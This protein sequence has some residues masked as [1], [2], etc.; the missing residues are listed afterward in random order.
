MNGMLCSTQKAH[1]KYSSA[2]RKLCS[3]LKDYFNIDKFYYGKISDS[4]LFIGF[5]SNLDFMEHFDT[6]EL[7]LEYPFHCHPKFH[8]V[9]VQIINLVEN[10]ELTKIDT[11]KNCMLKFNANLWLKSVS[12][13]GNVLEE[14]GF[15]SA[16]SDQKQSLFLFNQISQL[17]LLMKSFQKNN[18]NLF[19][20]L[21]E[22]PVNLLS[23]I[24]NDFYENRI[25][26]SDPNYIAKQNFL[27]E[28]EIETDLDLSGAELETIQLILKGCTASQIAKQLYRSKR[29][30]EHRVENIKLKLGCSS[31]QELIQKVQ[32]LEYF[33]CL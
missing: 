31:K 19:A 18:P 6:T 11:T 22:T 2:I 25:K 28:L 5:D 29:T 32:E 13:T 14:F 7:F 20:S 9:G 17:N 21:Y 8:T 27:K 10:L 24:G 26:R 30:I 4:G 15:H 3:T 12:R 16:Q 23:V 33:R 1:E